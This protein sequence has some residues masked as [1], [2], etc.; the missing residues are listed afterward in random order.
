MERNMNTA[1][2]RNR[3]INA[4]SN[5]QG[6]M[7][8]NMKGMMNNMETQTLNF[9][10]NAIEERISTV[11]NGYDRAFRRPKPVEEE[12]L[13]FVKNEFGA[14]K[15]DGIRIVDLEVGEDGIPKSLTFNIIYAGRVIEKYRDSEVLFDNRGNL[16]YRLIVN[17]NFNHEQYVGGNGF[18]NKVGNF[19]NPI[20]KKHSESVKVENSKSLKRA[21]VISS[22]IAVI[23]VISTIGSAKT[24]MEYKAILKNTNQVLKAYNLK[25]EGNTLVKRTSDK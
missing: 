25:I 17:D 14:K 15:V 13:E 16:R 3:A 12:I 1:I 5:M 19:N 9:N 2:R 20:K 6:N 4:Q 21:L 24:A 18:A 11:L 8:G 22:V 23:A 7:D 10:L